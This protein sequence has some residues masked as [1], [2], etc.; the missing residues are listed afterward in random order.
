[1]SDRQERHRSRDRSSKKRS[2]HRN[3]TPDNELRQQMPLLLERINALE[4]Q[5]R[6]LTRPDA[7]TP[8]PTTSRAPSVS[9]FSET[10]RGAEAPPA[11]EVTAV[12][13]TV[14]LE[15]SVADRIATAIQSTICNSV[16]SNQHFYI[17]NF[18]PSLH[19][20]EVWCNEV[21]QAKVINGWSD[22]ECLSRIGNC[23][24]GNARL[25]LNEWSTT[26][27][28]WSNFKREFKPLCPKNL[29]VA[30]ILFSVMSTNSDNYSTYADYARRS[31]LRLRIV[32]G[33]SE[34]LIA[35]IIIRGI[36]DPQIRAAATNAKLMPC[37]LVDFF[38][39]Y[40]KPSVKEPR[41]K[42]GSADAKPKRF[43]NTRK[44]RFEEGK[45]F[46]CGLAG[47]RQ[48]RCHKRTR[49]E[50]NEQLPTNSNSGQSNTS[51]L[52][53][54]K[55]DPCSFCK[56]PGH[57][58]ESCFA[59]LKSEARNK[60]NVNFC[61]ENIIKGNNDVVVAVIQ[62][63]PTDI[64]IDSGSTISLISTSLLKH[65]DCVR[66]PAF[67]VLR[68]IG[69]QEIESTYYVTLPIEFDEITMEVDLFVVA[70]EYMN[71]PVIIGT[72]VLNRNGVTYVRTSERQYIRHE[73][74]SPAKVFVIEADAQVP[75]K[76]TLLDDDFERLKVLINEFSDYFITGTA[77]TTVNTGS[78]CIRLNSD[79][80]VKYRPY[81]LSHSE[82][83]RVREIVKDLLDKCVIRESESEYASP[84]LLVKKKDG[85]DR[86]CVDFRKL[87]ELT[88]K[89]RFPLP[90]IDSHI[91]RLGQNTYFTSLDM[92]TGFHQIPMDDESI[93]KT[94][95]VTP[96]GHYEYLKMPHGL[97]NAPVVYQ[98]I[99]SKTLQEL[100]E[101]GWTLVYIDDV[102][103]L[104]DSIEEGFV[105]L[106][107]ALEVLTKAGFSINLKKCTFLST[108][109]EY[110]GRTISRGQ[111]R[112]SASKVK[113]L[114]E[115]PTPKTVK[116]VRQFLGLASYFRRYIAGFA[117]KVACIA[118][119]TKKGVDFHWGNDQETARQEV[120][121]C[122]TQEP[123]LAIYDPKLPIEV[124]T[125]ASS[126]GY[127][128][129]L[130]Q[131]DESEMH[132]SNGQVERYCRTLLNM[133]RI[134]V[135][136][137]QEKWSDVMWRLQLILN[138]T[139]H[140]TTQQSPL[141]LLVGIEA[142]TPVIRN[143]VRDVAFEG[144]HANRE[145]LREMSRQRA[146]ERLRKN[147]AQQDAY[148]NSGRRT[149]RAF[150]VGSMAF[151]IK[152][153]QTTGKLDSCMRGPYKV[154]KVLPNGRY[155]LQLVSGSYGKSTQAAAEFMVPWKGEWTPEICAAY[156]EDADVDGPDVMS[157]PAAPEDVQLAGPSTSREHEDVL[158]S[159]A[160]V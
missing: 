10:I 97:A 38:S 96:E 33:L 44:R 23:L 35:A 136:H 75:V 137:R 59:K 71:T 57:R 125:D 127:G 9:R 3:R 68:G 109:I 138:I 83:L 111:V 72:D 156:F 118:K 135:N 154:V 77:N 24:K 128:A 4:N 110:L 61:R 56:K 28:S 32:K 117:S 2:R 81:R 6:Q 119:L 37:D 145:A 80:P 27:R 143:L 46:N 153:A 123:V 30:D 106:R 149:P 130:L 69:G 16:R 11:S 14:D 126:V 87:N 155:E 48:D 139:K 52:P 55:S 49:I 15:L 62:G 102:L 121:A 91:D 29:D 157:G 158:Q 108:E 122:L 150:E 47:H 94:A 113:A 147:Q 82:T 100:I 41:V 12:P 45:C 84:I 131:I 65:F 140:R 114:V 133:I 132:Q 152:K 8:A 86:M 144:S 78:M 19:D 99:I 70:A 160:A 31:L 54:H 22:N 74:R 76:T 90:L 93:H 134:E 36:M 1:M 18:D 92:A 40:V 159:G 20:I 151:V 5:P 98:R 124:H 112:P 50:R 142:A 17:S 89:D 120:I 105:R 141:N 66:R 63:V 115:S 64:L 103:I 25:W 53:L 85:A 148:V 95:F 26:D 101:P 34:D 107:K 13:T 79:T 116:Q 39:I 88:V 146:S 7:S 60:N 129:V 21:D 67:R 58:V 104:S 43:D 42:T 73:D 51:T